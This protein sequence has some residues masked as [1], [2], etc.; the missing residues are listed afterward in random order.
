[1]Q[2]YF[3]EIR[4]ENRREVYEARL[5]EKKNVGTGSGLGSFVYQDTARTY[6][7][8]AWQ[9]H[10]GDWFRRTD[11]EKHERPLDFRE[12]RNKGI[13][14]KA[15]GGRSAG[16]LVFLVDTSGSNVD[17][18]PA[19]LDKVQEVLDL[20]AP[21]MT[22]LVPCDD[23]V[24]AVHE[25]PEGGRVPESLEGGGGTLLTPALEWARDNVPHADGIIYLTDGYTWA[26]D[27]QNMEEPE[28]PLLWLCFGHHREEDIG[29]SVYPFGER[30]PVL[31]LPESRR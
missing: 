9:E 8:V 20:F 23:R 12:F 25:I 29:E 14:R 2:E 19:M 4:E 30:V 27:W 26:D 28:R 3:E 31:I 18:V 21:R 22:Y 1:L 5:N 13:V 6:D 11:D 7:P 17:K 24:Q 15:R 10:L 16:D